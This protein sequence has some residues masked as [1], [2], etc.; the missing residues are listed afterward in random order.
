MFS[1]LR[2]GNLVYV[3]NK[4][5]GLNVTIGQIIETNATDFNNGYL[6]VNGNAL[7]NITANIEGV[8]RKFSNL[9]GN[10]T[11]SSYDNGMT[12]ITDSRDIAITEIHNIIKQSEL[13]LSNREYDEKIVS[14][15]KEALAKL[16]PQ[17]AE[18]KK[19]EK[20]MADINKRIDDMNDKFDKLIT[21]LSKDKQ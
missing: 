21:A 20:E 13:R 1:S 15:G 19:R 18:D 10:Q 17:Y 14:S 6:P 3:I 11:L 5:G 4:Q 16:N 8:E 7:I 2:Q 12:I 9:P